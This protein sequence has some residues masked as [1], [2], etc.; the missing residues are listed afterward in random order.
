MK[1]RPAGETK[2]FVDWLLSAE[3]QKTVVEVGYF[4]VR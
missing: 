3:G 4:P 1:N 2:Q